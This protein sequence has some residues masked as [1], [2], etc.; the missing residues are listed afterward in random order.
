[1]SASVDG[2][3]DTTAS[4]FHALVNWGDS[5]QWFPADI[6]AN[7][8]GVGPATFLIKGT[9]VYDKACASN[10]PYHVVVFVMGPDGTSTSDETGHANVFDMP[11]GIAGTPPPQVAYSLP[12][13]NVGI[14]LNPQSGQVG[15]FC[16][17]GVGFRENAVASMSA[18]VDG[19]PDTTASDFHALVNWGDTDQWFPADIAMNAGGVGPATFLIKGTHV[20]DKACASNNP[21][22]IV[23]FVMGPD[24]T[25]TSDETGHANVFD[26]PSGIAGTPPPQVAYSLPP[27][28]VGI[29]LNPQTGLFNVSAQ[30]GVDFPP[31]GAASMSADVNG[32]PDSTASDFHAFINWGDSNQWFAGEIVQ[33][34]GSGPATYLIEGSHVYTQGSGANPY[35]VVVFVLGPDGTSVSELTGEATVAPNPNPVQ[36]SLNAPDVTDANASSEVPYSLQMTFQSS[37]TALVSGQSVTAATVQVQAPNGETLT[38]KLVSTALSGNTDGQGNASTIAATYQITPPGGS[39]TAA[40]VGTYTVILGGSPVTDL[41]GDVA[42]Q[43]T[44][45]TFQANVAEAPLDGHGE[46]VQGTVGVPQ[47]N[48]VL[49]V[50]KDEGEPDG[51]VAEI[52]QYQAEVYWDT[53]P[54]QAVPAYLAV[55]N[56]ELAVEGDAPAN[57]GAGEHTFFAVVAEKESSGAQGKFPGTDTLS[58][59]EVNLSVS[60]PSWEAAFQNTATDALVDARVT[61]VGYTGPVSVRVYQDLGSGMRQALGPAQI[62]N[63]TAGTSSKIQLHVSEAPQRPQGMSAINCLVVVN[64]DNRVQ[65]TSTANN[66]AALGVEETE[67]LPLSYELESAAPLASTRMDRVILWLRRHKAAILDQANQWHITPTA[68]AGAIAWEAWFNVQLTAPT[69]GD[70]PKGPGKV[71]WDSDSAAAQVE[72]M[73]YLPGVSDQQRQTLTLTDNRAIEYIAAIMAAYADDYNAAAREY[74]TRHKPANPTPLNVFRDDPAILATF[75]NGISYS[76][77]D[78][79]NIATDYGDPFGALWTKDVFMNPFNSY[80]RP[81]N[82]G[83]FFLIRLEAGNGTYTPQPNDMGTWVDAHLTDLEQGLIGI[84]AAPPTNLEAVATALAHSVEYYQQFVSAAYSKYLGRSASSSEVLGWATQMQ[85][86]SLSDE[87][88]EADFIGSAEYIGAHGGPGAGWVTGMYHD[89]LGRS[90]SQAEINGWVSALNNGVPAQQIAYGFA[91]SGE[92]EAQRV[93]GDYLTFLGR[94]A[95]PTESNGWVAAFQHGSTNEDVVAGFAGSAEY[96]NGTGG[97]SA[98]VWIGSAYQDVLGRAPSS[99]ELSSALAAL[100]LPANLASAASA[101]AHGLEH[102]DQFIAATYQRYLGR[103]PSAGEVAGWAQQMQNGLSDEHLEADFI[104]SAEYIT[105]HGGPGAGWVTGMYQDL[106]GRSPSQTE[107]DGWVAALNSGA[108]TQQIAYGFAASGER[109]AQR[110]NGDYLTFLGRLASPTEINGWVAAFQHG[111][112]NEDL[113]ASFVGSREYFDG[114]AQGSDVAWIAFAFRDILNRVPS[115]DEVAGWSGMLN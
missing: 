96:F 51:G 27:S 107:V 93:N 99:A 94:P 113:V 19:V 58:P 33:N 39:W 56:N 104:G 23:V 9:H 13:S 101:L 97:G 2:V 21:Y 25:S 14:A 6:A 16:Y 45:G 26:M 34:T 24:G 64:D 55:S 28:N 36:V 37:S 66:T 11:S 48:V 44:V 114:T 15:L 80:I 72:Q 47:N 17:T 46:D 42:T 67:S 79:Q 106:V 88:L 57:L 77:A 7:A 41:E 78:L 10:N 60:N 35:P 20:Y 85:Q 59:K 4:D 105:A 86:G 81:L 90:P 76:K 103:S 30:A 50:F 98:T 100:A 87:Q 108:S 74:D 29:A 75:Y 49:A 110:V 43:G 40:P 65:Q 111:S 32:V 91:A 70:N 22:H 84:N 73:G 68:I 63:V 102:Y 92:R 89:L 83:Y 12:P 109:E 62:V 54:D 3:P 1:M 53:M 95:S 52:A 31:S 69:I 5:D 8:G 71:H 61:S 82:A 38:A 115:L 112:S 18:S